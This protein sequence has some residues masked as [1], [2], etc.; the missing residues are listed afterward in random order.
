MKDDTRL[1]REKEEQNFWKPDETNTSVYFNTVNRNKRS[2]CVNLKH[3]K[4]K[5]IILELAKKADVVF[6]YLLHQTLS[7]ISG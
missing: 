6:V 7:T 5:E 2:I 1:W 4:G 3:P